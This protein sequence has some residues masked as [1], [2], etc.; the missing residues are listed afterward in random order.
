MKFIDEVQIQ[1][2]A[3]NGGD[4]CI[5]FRRE[6]YIPKGGPDGG[7]GGNGGNVWIKTDPN[8]NTLSDYKFK[9][10]FIAGHGQSGKGKNKSG[11]KGLD[12]FIKVPIGT[13]IINCHTKEK[14][15]DLN[16]KEDM[17]LI[18][19][20]GWKGI[21][22]SKFKSSTNRTPHQKTT[23][24]KG[25]TCLII[26]QLI[27]IADVGIVGLPNS[28]K[29]TLVRSMSK[30]KPKIGAY[31]FTTL[32]PCLGTV[33][34]N[35]KESFVIADIPGLIQGASQGLGLGIQFLKHLEKCHILLHI[36]DL[37]PSIKIIFHNI[38]IIETELKQYNKQ[39]YNKTRWL[40][41]NKIDS[42]NTQEIK[43]KTEIILKTIKKKK[44]FFISALKK[45]GTKI[46]YY[47]LSQYLKKKI[48]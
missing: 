44:I 7:D 15:C 27:L 43:E 35:S 17:I 20:G 46:I 4:G 45:Y 31:P 2:T 30:A 41:F 39:L 28:G 3:G 37:L 19:K 40:I 18:V 12:I 9:K 16:N 36:V 22:N 24:K 21:G 1:V 6:K 29:S 23:G 48:K 25:E 42:L 34:I 14:I 10:Y 32:I 38:K 47:N 33:Q 26:L 11:K 5:H 8:L 13:R